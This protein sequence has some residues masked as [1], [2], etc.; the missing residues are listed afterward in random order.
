TEA[1]RLLPSESSNPR[2]S[3]GTQM[4]ELQKPLL[5]ATRRAL[6]G[7]RINAFG[8]GGRAYGFVVQNSYIVDETTGWFVF[9]TA[10]L[11]TNANRTMNDDQYE[12][13]E[14]ARPFVQ[15]LGE[16]L[17]REFLRAPTE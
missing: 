16:L 9:V 4:D 13:D 17:A 14:V 11:Y 7:H 2:F 3:V 8:K 10:N 5:M 12:Y 6:P 1:L 15:G